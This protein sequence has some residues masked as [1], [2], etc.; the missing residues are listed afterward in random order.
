MNRKLKLLLLATALLV[1]C[2]GETI[3]EHK[4]AVVTFMKGTAMVTK[5]SGKEALHFGDVID[6]GATI[7]TDAA[8]VVDLS[9]TDHSILRIKPSTT[10]SLKTMGE[11]KDGGL[12]TELN[13]NTGKIVNSVKK[14]QKDSSYKVVSPTMVAGVRGT[15]FEV[16]V[17]D[18][19]TIFVA[20]GSV[21]VESKIASK[22]E[23]VL[24]AD[25]GVTI[26]GDKDEIFHNQDKVKQILS[27]ITE[28]EANSTKDVMAA[29]KALPKVANEE[30]LKK[31]YNKD[32]EILVMKDGRELRGVTASMLDGKL[33]F[34][35]LKGSHLIK[36]E[37]VLRVKFVNE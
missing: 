32:I 34:Q 12:V 24:S 17:A 27:E 23:H 35:T 4:T 25:N 33:V 6:D 3:K 28:M 13:I 1:S 16:E 37:D 26:K 22:E 8:S 19:A 2:K 31:I 30:E 11:T 5:A 36:E 21:H 10:V 14:L 29:M 15:A 7:Q 9:F 18:N 20:E